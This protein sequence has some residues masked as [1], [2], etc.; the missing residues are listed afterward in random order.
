[1]L[2]FNFFIPKEFLTSFPKV[3]LIIVF[4]KVVFLYLSN[5]YFVPWR[6]FGLLEYKKLLISHILSY[7]LFTLI[8]LFFKN[9]FTPFPRSVIIIDFFISLIFLGF[10][11][12]SKR[13]IFETSKNSNNKKATII[14]GAGKTGER[15]ARELLTE[16]KSEFYPIGF[17]DDSDTKQGTYI[18]GIKVLG[19]IDDLENIAKRHD[20]K[21]LIIAIPSLP[22]KRVKSIFNKAKEVGINEIKIVPTIEKLGSDIAGIKDLKDISLEDLLARKPVEIDLKTV[23][24]FINNK[25]VLV[26]GAG[27]S[28][29][30]EIVRQLVKF[31]PKNILAFDIDETEL[32]NLEN[33]LKEDRV[34]YIVGDIKDKDKLKQIFKNNKI[35]VIFHA[36][37]YK[38]VPIMERFPEEAVKVN[39]FGTRNL[40]ELA[41][42]YNVEKFVNIS[43][44]KAVNPTSIMGATKRFAEMICSSYNSLNKTKFCSVRFG[45]VLG[46]RGSV[47]PLFLKQIKE[48]GPVTVT[49][50]EM[51]RY[52]MTIPEAVL[53]VFQAAAMSNGGEVFVLDMGEPVKIVNL[54]E[55]LIR[56]NGFEPYKDIEIVFIGLRPGEKL[57]EE[58]LTAEE[59]TIAT[60]HEKIFI[61]RTV[62]TNR[63]EI[64]KYIKKLMIT[65]NNTS[66]FEEIRNILKNIVPF[67]KK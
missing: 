55:E 10:I 23:K 17:L 41:V 1:M 14:I 25:V 48:G 9:F 42:N 35:D 26:T 16:N 15:I 3:F 38:H 7:S 13:L 49:H 51:K 56:L 22:Y 52:F 29:G 31:N 66:D 34:K 27:G 4:L 44:D 8:F 43:T 36:A 60:K 39:I 57:F 64:E 46:S 5:I 33:E 63:E 32:F 11:R 58:L 21:A 61:A 28:I 40:V 54:A 19:K 12:V 2:R 53:L 18:H 37:A 24:S 50:P 47:I 62:L 6:F 67:Y 59:G 45:N 30:S 20:I 65:I